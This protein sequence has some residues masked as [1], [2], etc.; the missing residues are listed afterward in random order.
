MKVP[1]NYDV[2]YIIDGCLQQYYSFN[3]AFKKQS[4]ANKKIPQNN[5]QELFEK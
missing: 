2:L 1:E 3:A 4:M 5:V